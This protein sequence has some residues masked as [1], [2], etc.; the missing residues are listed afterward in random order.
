MKNVVFKRALNYLKNNSRKGNRN[1]PQRTPI[2]QR[3]A[4]WEEGEFAPLYIM[5]ALI[6]GAKREKTPSAVRRAA[7][8][9]SNRSKSQATACRDLREL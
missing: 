3:F 8:S 5:R 7:V 9:P 6:K 4:F 2:W 1:F